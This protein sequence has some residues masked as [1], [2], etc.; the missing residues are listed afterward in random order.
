MKTPRQ[1]RGQ[2]A[3]AKALEHMQK[4]GFRLVWRNYRCRVGEI[5]I[6]GWDR[7]ILVFVEVRFRAKTTFGLAADTVNRT[8]QRRCIRAA[9]HFLQSHPNLNAPCRFDVL[10][11]DE[12]KSLNW[13]RD[14]YRL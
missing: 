4:L 9:Q 1:L 11:L 8:K 14:A 3:E 5:D 13:I 10:A 2:W 6:V 12:G 7:E